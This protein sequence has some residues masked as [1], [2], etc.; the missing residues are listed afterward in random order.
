[1]TREIPEIALAFISKAEGVRL[2]AYQDSVGVWTIGVGHTGLEVHGGLE[3]DLDQAMELLRIDLKTAAARLQ[4][5]VKRDVIDALTD[6]Q[7]AALLSFVFNLGADKD[8]TI[9]KRLNARAFD[10]VPVE[11]AR[12]VN[13]RVNGRLVKIKGLVNR[14]GAEIA[15]WSED[16]PGSV[17]VA[18]SSGRTR[19]LVTPPT[20]SDP[21][22]P[23][24]SAVL[25]TGLAGA[26]AS[27]PAVIKQVQ[28]TLTPVAATSP[29]VAQVI[30]ALSVIGALLAA[31]SIVLFWI[32]KQTARS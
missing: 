12:F 23:Q 18:L 27:A 14:R 7:Y 20:P 24:R 2:R 8:W 22:P 25:I 13:G 9:W 10:Q 6:N 21:V 29:A 26:A 16:E 3:I 30:T 31:A 17:D 19:D 32:H 4:S 15:L 11:M 1:M 28:D 5:V